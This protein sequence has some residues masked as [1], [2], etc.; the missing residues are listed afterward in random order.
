MYCIVYV[1]EDLSSVPID[2][3]RRQKL[4]PVGTQIVRLGGMTHPTESQTSIES[5]MRSPMCMLA[6][7]FR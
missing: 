5:Q 4:E 7:F 2:R 1:L 6:S 3:R